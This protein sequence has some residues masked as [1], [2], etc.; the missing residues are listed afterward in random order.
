[1]WWAVLAALA[2]VAVG[3]ALDRQSRRDPVLAR[4][5]PI[6]FRNFAQQALVESALDAGDDDGTLDDARLL[7]DR[8]PMP[9]ES[10]ADLGFAA[11]RVQNDTLSREALAAAAGRGWRSAVPQIVVGASAF[12]NGMWDVAA[13]RLAALWRTSVQDNRTFT[14]TKAMLVQPEVQAH[15]VDRIGHYT[16]AV[17]DFVDWAAN[18]LDPAVLRSVL[19]RLAARGATFDC[20]DMGRRAGNLAMAGR[21]DAAQA[22]WNGACARNKVAQPASSAFNSAA[23]DY[24]PGPFEWRYPEEPGVDSTVA[25][26]SD[27][28]YRLSFE[29]TDPM[30]KQLA[31]KIVRLGPGMHYATWSSGK[32]AKGAKA[33]TVY[34]RV[35]CLNPANPSR[36][37]VSK[38]L[39]EDDVAFTLPNENCPVQSV[40]LMAGQGVGGPGELVL[41]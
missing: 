2:V 9:E 32:I 15:F 5:V 16:P 30:M 26:G 3:Y 34:L 17:N 12:D 1:M 36:F 38:S 24:V 23:D 28:R 8:R 19:A 11:L 13:D 33:A 18:G 6:P 27:G 25:R 14:I 22:L 7:V 40:E 4:I 29:N 41:R 35:K 21:V 39:V 31:N 10:L 37:M 20:A